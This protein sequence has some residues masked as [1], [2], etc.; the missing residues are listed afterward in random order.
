MT[1]KVIL[2]NDQFIFDT[3]NYSLSLF[4]NETKLSTN[5]VNA[6]SVNMFENKVYIYLWRARV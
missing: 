1:Y 4:E 6:R 2:V 3:R 5:C